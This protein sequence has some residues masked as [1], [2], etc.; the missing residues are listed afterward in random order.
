MFLTW[1]NTKLDVT[2]RIS[3]KKY[4][5]ILFFFLWNVLQWVTCAVFTAVCKRSY[6]SMHMTHYPLIAWLYC[7]KNSYSNETVSV[8]D[9]RWELE[10][11]ELSSSGKRGW[12][13]V[14]MRLAKV[15]NRP[16]YE[17]GGWFDKL[18]HS[19]YCTACRAQPRALTSKRPSVSL[20]LSFKSIFTFMRI[21]DHG[22]GLL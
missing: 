22:C 3:D 19:C 4:S 1:I 10:V 21:Y 14:F 17:G 15:I 9:C 5:N 7:S 12:S 8:R 2:H 20:H 6:L 16:W 13:S 11:A 18:D